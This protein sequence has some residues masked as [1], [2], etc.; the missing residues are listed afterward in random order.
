MR[1]ALSHAKSHHHIHLAKSRSGLE[2]AERLASLAF[3]EQE[4]LL[5][6]NCVEGIVLPFPCKPFSESYETAAYLKTYP[7]PRGCVSK[8]DTDR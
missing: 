7:V 4:C 1:Q 5:A 2:A 6:G 8:L 3:Y